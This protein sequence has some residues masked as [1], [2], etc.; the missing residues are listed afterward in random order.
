MKK[1]SEFLVDRDN[2]ILQY[3]EYVADRDACSL[4]EAAR[5]S[6]ARAYKLVTSS[7]HPMAIMTA[8]RGERPININRVLN[9][10]LEQDLRSNGWGFIPVLGGTNERVKDPETGKETGEVKKID[11]EES[12]FII[13]KNKETFKKDVLDLVK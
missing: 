12:Y 4:Q 8:F 13:G 6:M 10:E 2:E 9:K 7:D 11:G 5:R 3:V 1:F